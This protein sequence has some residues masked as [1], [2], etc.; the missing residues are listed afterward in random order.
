MEIMKEKVSCMEID[1]KGRNET[2]IVKAKGIEN[3]REIMWM[4]EGL[5]VTM[6]V[7][8]F[9]QEAYLLIIKTCS[10]SCSDK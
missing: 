3:Q 10:H 9:G 8:S 6:P 2:D 5:S 7:A 4:N 1:G